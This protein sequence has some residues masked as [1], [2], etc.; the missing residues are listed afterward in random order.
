M[1]LN[2]HEYA[3]PKLR[4]HPVSFVTDLL[5]LFAELFPNS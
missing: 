3:S 4:N 5:E 1:N 2:M